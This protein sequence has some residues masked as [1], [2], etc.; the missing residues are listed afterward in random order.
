ML[1]AKLHG[2][3]P[4]HA[5]ML[6]GPAHWPLC[7]LRRQAAAQISTHAAVGA[8][9]AAEAEQQKDLQEVLRRVRASVQ[10]A[11]LQPTTHGEVGDNLVHQSIGSITSRWQ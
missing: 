7:R 3:L 2:P 5:G 8:Q 4:G 10:T 11:G 9:P 6:R 1:R